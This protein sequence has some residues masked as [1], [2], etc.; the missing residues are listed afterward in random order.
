MPDDRRRS[1]LASCR[2]KV[3]EMLEADSDFAQ[4]ERVIGHQRAPRG[5]EGGVAEAAH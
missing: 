5:G 1:R 4:I 3:I 2:A